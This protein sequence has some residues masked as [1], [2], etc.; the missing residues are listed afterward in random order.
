MVVHHVEVNQVGARIDY[1]TDLLAEP[2]EIRGQDARGDA[3]F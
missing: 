1:R 2:R 3:E